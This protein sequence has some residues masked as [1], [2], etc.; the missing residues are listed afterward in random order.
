M[1]VDED[2]GGGI[3][4]SLD[5]ARRGRKGTP[6]PAGGLRSGA[7]ATAAAVATSRPTPRG[8]AASR[9][10][11]RR[12]GSGLRSMLPLILSMIR[13]TNTKRGSNGIKYVLLK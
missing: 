8:R 9:G 12:G 7:W 11:D 1:L 5:E 13:T 4:A 10:G 3:V 2:E 6:M